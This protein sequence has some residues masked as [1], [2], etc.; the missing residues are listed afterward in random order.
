MR[1]TPAIGLAL[2]VTSGLG[3]L[4]DATAIAWAPTEMPGV[5]RT[6]PVEV[7]LDAS[8]AALPRALSADVAEPVVIDAMRVWSEAGSAFRFRYLGR[9]MTTSPEVNEI[10]FVETWDPALGSADDILA[11]TMPGYAGTEPVL[12]LVREDI[13]FNADEFDWSSGEAVRR[14]SSISAGSFATTILHELG[15]AVGLGHSEDMSAVMWPRVNGATALMPDDVAGIRTLYPV[16]EPLCTS[17]DQCANEPAEIDDPLRTASPDDQSN[18]SA[19]KTMSSR[20]SVSTGS[21]PA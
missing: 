14:G 15:H 8:A 1:W 6:L 4:A 5:W 13:V 12:T 2:V 10:T 17:D 21:V 18:S 11:V 20:T 3:V 19:L 7:G 9:V 16:G